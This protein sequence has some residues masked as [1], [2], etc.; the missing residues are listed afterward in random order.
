MEKLSVQWN[1]RDRKTL[2]TKEESSHLQFYLQRVEK[3]VFVLLPQK[4]TN[5]RTCKSLNKAENKAQVQY[6]G[7]QSPYLGQLGA[8]AR[9]VAFRAFKEATSRPT[10]QG[11]WRSATLR[12]HPVLRAPEKGNQAWLREYLCPGLRKGQPGESSRFLYDENGYVHMRKLQKM[13]RRRQQHMISQISMLYPMKILVGPTQEQE[14]E[15]YPSSNLAGKSS[16]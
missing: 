7:A 4:D 16:Q 9:G 11:D 14:L 2:E 5:P 12:G 13:L 1:E 3:C 15:A 10:V 8:D 6:A